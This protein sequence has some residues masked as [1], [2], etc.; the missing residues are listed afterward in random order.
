MSLF[1]RVRE[2]ARWEVIRFFFEPIVGG[3]ARHPYAWRYRT[4]PDPR[5]EVS[6][7]LMRLVAKG[8]VLPR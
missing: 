4:G 8:E 5:P 6:D 3:Y 1:D 2:D 7:E